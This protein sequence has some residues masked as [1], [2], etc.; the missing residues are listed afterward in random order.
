MKL[1]DLT[2]GLDLLRLGTSEG[3]SEASK[4]LKDAII[5]NVKF[6][7]LLK[8]RY[9]LTVIVESHSSGSG[10]SGDELPCRGSGDQRAHTPLEEHH[11]P[12]RRLLALLGSAQA[13]N[14]ESNYRFT[15]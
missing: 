3:Q 5:G 1:V 14:A 6:R 8:V 4:D 15:G 12:Y 7:D 10:F 9:G 2:I 11:N 13:G